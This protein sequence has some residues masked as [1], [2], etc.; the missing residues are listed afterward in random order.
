MKFFFLALKVW[1]LISPT[2]RDQT[3][4]VCTGSKESQPLDLQGSSR[5]MSTWKVNTELRWLDGITD[6]TDTCVSELREMV[7]DREAWRA[8][9]G[10]P[11]W[12]PHPPRAGPVLLTLLFPALPVPP[13]CRVLCASVYASVGVRDSRQLWAAVLQAFV[14]LR[15]IPDASLERDV[16]SAALVLPQADSS[17]WQ[18]TPPES[19]GFLC[20]LPREVLATLCF[21]FP[22]QVFI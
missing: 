1:E 17:C 8:A 7:M 3:H 18:K 16:V 2:S 21:E 9:A 20:F 5:L 19:L 13:S 15:R 12:F 4:A 22:F 6:S 10:P 14:C 11:L